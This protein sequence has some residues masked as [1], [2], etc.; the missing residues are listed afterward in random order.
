M[1]RLGRFSQ[2]LA[3]SPAGARR[4]ATSQ[5]WCETDRW[6]EMNSVLRSVRRNKCRSTEMGDWLLG[7]DSEGDDLPRLNVDWAGGG[8]DAIF[9]EIA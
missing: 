7:F 9:G 6:N 5:L 1:R 4:N 2:R 3:T 8:C